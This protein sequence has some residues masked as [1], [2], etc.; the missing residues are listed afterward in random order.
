MVRV[1]DVVACPSQTKEGK[2]AWEDDYWLVLL[3]G[4]VGVVVETYTTLDVLL[5]LRHRRKVV[6][7]RDWLETW[8]VLDEPKP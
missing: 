4:D 5:M 8:E 3:P 1:G 2:Y 7:F 6:V